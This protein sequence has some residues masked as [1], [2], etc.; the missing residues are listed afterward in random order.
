MDMNTPQPWPM[1]HHGTPILNSTLTP[2]QQLYWSAYNTTTYFTLDTPYHSLLTSHVVLL[3]L[4]SFVLYP[5]VLILNNLNSK[6]FI[7]SLYLQSILSIF[8][9][10]LYI[11]FIHNV[12]D[13]FPGMAYTK[14]IHGLIIFTLLNVIFSTL[15]FRFGSHNS[16][17]PFYASLSP[18]TPSA[19][20]LLGL[21]IN[22]KSPS[23]SIPLSNILSSP[24]ATLFEEEDEEEHD[25]DS[26]IL[27]EP[28]LSSSPSSYQQPPSLLSTS[29]NV[30]FN[31]TLWLIFIYYLVLLPTGVACLNLMGKGPRIFNLL[32]HFIK[33]GVF[34]ALGILSLARYCGAYKTIGGSWNYSIIDPKLNNSVF[35]KLNKI[36]PTNGTILTFEFIESFL[37]FFYGSTNIFLEHL[38]SN[39]GTW[40][41]K[42][43]QHV[44]IAFM[45]LG[46]G[47]CGLIT[48]FK[49][50]DWKKAS[51]LKNVK[52]VD[53]NGKLIT[54]GFSPNPFPVFTIFWTGLL[55]SKH[56]QASELSTAIHV[57]WGSLLTYGSFFRIIT[58]FVI[59]SNTAIDLFQ[60]YK[61]LTELIT[62]F[63][64]LCG[65]LIFMES[66][67][68]IIEAIAYRG[69]T[70]MFTI[71]VSVGVISLVMAW[72][73]IVFV[74][75]DKIQS[76]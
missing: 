51:F 48:E 4:A 36:L 34:F 24:S 21:D 7:P 71:N 42:D 54:V 70:S 46:A 23:S 27:D 45:Y 43:L 67:D 28:T 38:A 19:Y 55:M 74:I 47:L 73:M 63:C 29:I 30:L 12:P 10:F 69:L 57:Q 44:S 11:I 76:M 50:S 33:G 68:Q 3:L 22:P 61:P 66:T 5:I 64:L 75:K 32:A 58:F 8:A 15:H 59:N 52:D 13:L 31:L 60:P 39:D 2:G 53:I 65:G 62:S 17:F 35:I 14:M 26:F 16:S 9:S 1:A 72:I 18:S 25:T 56:A 20:K 49:L 6:W 37:I 41:A 40:T